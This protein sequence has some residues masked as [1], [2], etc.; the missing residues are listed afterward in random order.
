MTISAFRL[1]CCEPHFHCENLAKI[2]HTVAPLS[3]MYEHIHKRSS[4]DVS[5]ILPKGMKFP[6][7]M[8]VEWRV[9]LA[10]W[11]HFYLL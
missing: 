7:K 6:E 3:E 5:L 4:S 10:A 8:K 2:L 11:H 9:R 1:F